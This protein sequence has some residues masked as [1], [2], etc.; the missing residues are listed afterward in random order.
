VNEGD[1]T[2]YHG[3]QHRLVVR[4]SDGPGGINGFRAKL[5]LK[6]HAATFYLAE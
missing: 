1:A 3:P 5:H 4:A 2:V 6:G